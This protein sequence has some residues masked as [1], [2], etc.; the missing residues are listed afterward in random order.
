MVHLLRQQLLHNQ[1]LRQLLRSVPSELQELVWWVPLWLLLLGNNGGAE[2]F[3]NSL[4]GDREDF[5]FEVE[6]V[7]PTHFTNV[8]LS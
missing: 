6:T 2:H 3:S 4:M 1:C 5:P 7:G 8:A